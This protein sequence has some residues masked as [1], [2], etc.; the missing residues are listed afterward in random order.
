MP[1][2]RTL[3]PDH[4]LHRKVG[5]LDNLTYRLWVGMILE[6][7]DQGRL[8]ASP[9]ALRALVFGLTPGVSTRHVENALANLHNTGLI[10]RYEV[11]GISYAWFP[12]WHD[13]QRIDRPQVS[14][15]PACPLDADLLR[16]W[17]KLN[18]PQIRRT[19]DEP[20]TIIR[21]GSGREVERK[22]KEVEVPPP[23]PPTQDL[24]IDLQR[25]N[26]KFGAQLPP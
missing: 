12:S 14:R 18:Q 15:L 9:S 25:L 13:H 10:V 8:V 24:L 23:N 26:Q 19:L 7:D 21:G 5:P 2:I 1:R 16:T 4:R 6:A 20:S 22:G 11:D 17:R 3:K